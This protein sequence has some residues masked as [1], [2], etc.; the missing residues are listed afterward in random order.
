MTSDYETERELPDDIGVKSA[1]T[2]IAG[3]LGDGVND[4]S[5]SSLTPVC[6]TV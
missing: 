6:K 1:A 4:Y 3:V 5:K 2:P